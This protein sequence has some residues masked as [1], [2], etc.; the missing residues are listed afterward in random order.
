MSTIKGRVTKILPTKQVKDAFINSFVIEVQDGQYSN[1]VYFEGYKKELK[2]IKE[3]D[4][5]EVHY[6]LRS[7]EHEG[8]Y[9]SSI[10]FWKVDKLTPS[11][12]EPIINDHWQFRENLGF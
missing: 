7:R 8:K 10:S 5:V 6:N 3:G 12:P 2:N 9:Y 11:A 4:E 1:L